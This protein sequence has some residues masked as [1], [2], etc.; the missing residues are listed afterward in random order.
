MACIAG[1]GVLDPAR[2]DPESASG[3]LSWWHPFVLPS[4]HLSSPWC[5]LKR[6]GMHKLLSSLAERT[7][8]LSW[9]IAEG[10]R[11]LAGSPI[12]SIL[13]ALSQEEWISCDRQCGRR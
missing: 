13:R 11:Y 1:R 3:L 5:R 8:L 7:P 12:A 10:N 4:L 6:L 9:P 2:F